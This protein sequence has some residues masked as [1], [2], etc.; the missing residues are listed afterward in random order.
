M[1]VLADIGER[2]I[3]KI[4]E[5][6]LSRG[7]E[8]VGIGDDCAA[9]EFQGEYL[10]VSTDMVTRST[11]LPVE[12]KPWEI[13]WFITAVTLSDIA[14]KGGSPL[15]MVLSL[16]LP[17]ETTEDFIIEL[18]RG[19]DS[20]IRKYGASIVG[21][22]TKE[23]EELT[24]CGTALGVVPKNEFM[25]RKGL[26]VGDVLAVTGVL[27]KAAAGYLSLQSGILDENVRK[28]LF[29]PHPRIWEGRSLSKSNRVHACMDLSDGLSAS[30]YQLMELNGLGFE[31]DAE[32]IP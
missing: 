21:G 22:D 18:M 3:I 16:G 17:R 4:I 9:F 1:R 8:V 19:A 14:A 5:N 13:G 28:G 30:L 12:M 15:G 29:Q 20:C 32:K 24:L 2:G 7:S 27:G 6:I 31:V 23:N 11:H 10:L 26:Q 25:G